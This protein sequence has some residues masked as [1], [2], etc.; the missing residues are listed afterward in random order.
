MK[1]AT[2]AQVSFIALA[3]VAVYS[4]V[5]AVRNDERRTACTSLCAINPA[6]AGRNR[7]AP[8]F[9]LNDLDGKPVKLSQ[10][11]G[12]TV[13]LNFWTKTCRPCLEEMASLAEL[14]KIGKDRGDFVVVTVSTDETGQDARD[15]LN[16]VLNGDVPFVALVDPDAKIV[17]DVF[18]TRLFPETW[19]IDPGG[20]IR[21]RYDGGRN[22]SDA[23]AVD[24]A[25]MVARPAGCPVE[26]WK[27]APKGDFG[28]LCR[29]GDEG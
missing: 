27:G 18:G 22:W 14:A 12:K 8:D 28:D 25:A 13:F 21:A 5:G 15:T 6:H 3:A 23:L 26:F 1:T 11:R 29:G 19:V 24:F 20:T 9:E 10:F 4:F 7:R 2:L 16:T 17:H